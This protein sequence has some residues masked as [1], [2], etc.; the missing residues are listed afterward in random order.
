EGVTGSV[1]LARDRVLDCQCALKLVHSATSEDLRISFLR[2]AMAAARI[3]CANVVT[4]FDYDEWQG[5][6][7]IAMENLEGETLETRLARQRSLSLAHC[8][9]LI[10]HVARGLVRTHS[11]GIVHR[12]LKPAN[13]FITRG[14]DGEVCK[15]LDF[16]IAKQELCAVAAFPSNYGE[17]MGT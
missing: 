6:P 15:V 17:S 13:I 9:E 16:G 1:W 3:R 12:D 11:I 4:I 7:Y 14:D 5:L 2:E 10:V 8:Y